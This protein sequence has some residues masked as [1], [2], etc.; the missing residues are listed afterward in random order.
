VPGYANHNAII[1]LV[2]AGFAPVQ[3]IRFATADAAGLL[4]IA[5]R[6]GTVAPGKAADL[7]IVKGTPDRHIE[8]IRNVAYVFKDG[9]AYDPAKLR[10]SA[11]GMLGQH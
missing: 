6:V 5:D 1:A 8:D 3:A 2:R 4:A 9:V 11:K 7:L 10:N